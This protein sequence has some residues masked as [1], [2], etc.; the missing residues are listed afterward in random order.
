MMHENAAGGG[1]GVN[2]FPSYLGDFMEKSLY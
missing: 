2:S 1:G